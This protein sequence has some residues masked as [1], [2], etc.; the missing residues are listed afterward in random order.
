MGGTIG[1]AMGSLV[2]RGTMSG[3]DAL[4]G[5]EYQFL[6]T[7]E[8]ALVAMHDRSVGATG[9]YVESPPPSSPADDSEV[10]DFAVYS[11]PACLI[12]AQVKG[13]DSHLSASDATKILLRLITGDAEQYLVLTNRSPGLGL[14]ELSA[15]LGISSDSGPEFRSTLRRLVSRSQQV[16]DSLGRLDNDAWD[17]L[18]RCRVSIDA[19]TTAELRHEM[20]ERVRFLR[21]RYCRGPAGWDAAGL[22]L[23]HLLWNV[24]ASAAGPGEPLIELNEIQAQLAIDNAALAAAVYGKA[25]AAHVNTPPRLTDIAR[26]ELLNLIAQRLPT[27]NPT[28]QVPTCALYGLSGIGKT[29]VAVAW[30]N[31]RSDDYQVVFWIDASSATSIESSFIAVDGWLASHLPTPPPEPNLFDRVQGGLARL[32][33]SWLIVFDNALD[34]RTVKHW[35]PR[36]GLGHAVVTT[37]DPTA[38]HGPS[39]FK[40]EIPAMTDGQASD[41]LMRRLTPNESDDLKENT[42][43]LSDLAKRLQRWPL[44]LELASAYLLDCHEGLAGAANYERLIMRALGDEQS[45]PPGYP[46]TLVGAV[47]FALRRMEELGKNNIAAE[48]ARMATRFAAFMRPRQIPLHLLMACVWC[49]LEAAMRNDLAAFTPYTGEDPPIG[50]IARELF[51]GSLVTSDFPIFGGADEQDTPRSF[52]FS[53]S[54]NEIVQ[55]II[56]SEAAREE[57]TYNVVT[58]LAYFAQRWIHKLIEAE[59]LDLTMV[60]LGHCVAVSDAAISNSVSNYCTALLWGNTASALSLAEEWRIADVY[61]RS[62][63]EYLESTENPDP[64]MALAT[65]SQLAHTAVRKGE[66]PSEV[67]DEVC[68]LLRKV[69]DWFTKAASADIGRTSLPTINALLI[70]QELQQDLPS[71]GEIRSVVEELKERVGTLPQDDKATLK[72]ME[73]DRLNQSLREGDPSVTAERIRSLIKNPEYSFH[74]VTLQRF[75]VEVYMQLEQWKNAVDIVDQMTE[76]AKRGALSYVDVSSLVINVGNQCLTFAHA[77]DAEAIHLVSRA[78]VLASTYESRGNTFR[79]GDKAKIETYRAYVS[80]LAMQFSD[81]ARVMNEIDSDELQLAD[82]GKFVGMRD[83]YRVMERWLASLPPQMRSVDTREHKAGDGL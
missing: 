1:Y 64:F 18:A 81:T 32:R 79:P 68:G 76:F 19:R 62:E 17:R 51:R 41:L 71:N 15:L 53:V 38:W 4:R 65:Y 33:S 60:F 40:I 70:A 29:S 59:R 36:L 22:L 26:P 37:T 67:V 82:Q 28:P 3:Q 63:V 7:L 27:P 48:V 34:P 72:A 73:V 46:R 50:E 25:W 30:A 43:Q 35:L 44:A 55:Q 56:R 78:I 61:L 16:T 20:R 77:A 39:I 47:I 49:D 5:F 69:L 57:V 66:R 2:Q 13:G 54:M 14:D 8:Y 11:G 12:R 10:V 9:I 75:L 42:R 74:H 58:Q 31:D 24:L 52:D 83:L 23:G 45:V 6:R 80:A 21:R